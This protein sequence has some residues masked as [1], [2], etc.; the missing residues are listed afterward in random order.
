MH[1]VSKSMRYFLYTRKSTDVEDKQV[2]S[3]ESQL[4][5]LRALARQERLNVVEV[6]VEKRYYPSKKSS[7]RTSPSTRAKRA[8]PR[9]INGFISHRQKRISRKWV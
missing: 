4:A 1:I 7:A 2:L 5:E 3:I 6:F 8:A 9:R